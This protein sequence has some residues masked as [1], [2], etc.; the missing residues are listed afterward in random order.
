[1]GRYWRIFGVCPIKDFKVLLY[2]LLS[3]FRRWL[4]LLFVRGKRLLMGIK[5]L[6]CKW[7]RQLSI[8]STRWG[9]FDQESEDSYVNQGEP[10]VF[11]RLEMSGDGLES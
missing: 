4:S 6:G 10:Y 9:W 2:V 7:S 11:G 3:R 5:E 8:L 1:M